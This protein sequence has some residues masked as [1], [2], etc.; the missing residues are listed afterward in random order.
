MKE[1]NMTAEE[2]SLQES[3]VRL[4]RQRHLE[5]CLLVMA[6]F[7]VAIFF[8]AFVVGE[9][10]WGLKILGFFFLTLAVSLLVQVPFFFASL[11]KDPELKKAKEA[12]FYFLDSPLWETGLLTTLFLTVKASYYQVALA[13]FLSS[14]IAAVFDYRGKKPWLSPACLAALGVGLLFPKNYQVPLVFGSLEGYY[15]CS[16]FS[17]ISITSTD[18]FS[19]LILSPVGLWKL[20]IGNYLGT[21]ASPFAI[22]FVLIGIYLTLR[23][24]RDGW[25]LLTVVLSLYAG[26][27]ILFLGLGDG[28]WSFKDALA[29][30][31]L[32]SS[33]LGILFLAPEQ[34]EEEF[35]RFRNL[36][37]AVLLALLVIAF[38]LIRADGLDFLEAFLV[39][40]LVQLLLASPRFVKANKLTS[41]V[42]LGLSLAG[43]IAL[44][45]GYGLSH[46][47]DPSS[48]YFLR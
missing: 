19:G 31:F 2:F 1:H 48:G 11:H 34:Q 38:R 17:M 13:V 24:R 36:S 47:I 39:M 43:L 26:F 18:G 25:L 41:G 12:L 3:F 9:P 29:E 35:D 23:K 45:L 33:L 42:L 8:N 4:M 37:L 44:S 40:Q 6:L 46:P 22:A 21:I 32:G 20:F 30:T 10:D 14:L 7:V 28:G 16:L 15:S 27:V 5:L